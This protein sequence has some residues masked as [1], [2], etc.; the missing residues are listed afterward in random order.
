MIAKPDLEPQWLTLS[1]AS[2]F[3]GVHPTTLREWVD[4]GTLPAFRT[5]GGHRRFQVHDLQS[6]LRNRKSMTLT[7]TPDI[8]E[9]YP[10][11]NIRRQLGE[12]QVTRQRWYRQLSDEQ[13]QK[14]RETGRRMLGLL[15][16]YASR[17]ENAD[18]FLN[19]G[20]T[21]ARSYGRDLARSGLSASNVVRAFLFI[22]RAILNA[23]HQP[24][25]VAAPNDAEGMR[26]YQRINGFMDEMLL[27]TLDAYE[28]E[29]AAAKPL[30]LKK[31]KARK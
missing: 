19:E 26:L 12:S 11:D 1:E 18:H 7:Q 4:A 10:L 2:Q 22:R 29:R 28:Q 6:F 16:Q 13:R 15:I 17:H 30:A 24:Q 31:P 5:P 21:I 9:R 8:A 20:K 23:T 14:E 3:L 27:A 25:D